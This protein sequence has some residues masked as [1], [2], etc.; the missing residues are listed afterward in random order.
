MSCNEKNFNG[1][2]YQVL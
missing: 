2:G 1:D